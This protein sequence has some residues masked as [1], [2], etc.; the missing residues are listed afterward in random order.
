MKQ[1]LAVLALIGNLS[2]K[3]LYA[4]NIYLQF[5]DD[6]LF[7]DDVK[8]PT[9]SGPNNETIYMNDDEAVAQRKERNQLQQAK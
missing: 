7:D 2:A 8:N 1:N 5:L 9:I 4:D 6:T 3:K